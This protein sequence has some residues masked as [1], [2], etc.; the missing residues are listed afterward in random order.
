MKRFNLRI[1]GLIFNEQGKVLLCDETHNGKKMIKFP[2][3][4]ME[5]GESPTDCLKRELMEE[6]NLTLL[7]AEL[8]YVTDFFQ[9]SCFNPKDQVVSIYYKCKVG[10]DIVTKEPNVDAKW[11]NLDD[12]NAEDMTFPI[13]K[14]VVN[15]LKNK[16]IHRK[17]SDSSGQ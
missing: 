7:Y 12:L 5:W 16:E 14:H 2:G 3:G 8:F 1:Y 11:L 4:G 13:D 15:L 9:V 17:T 10:G 6:L